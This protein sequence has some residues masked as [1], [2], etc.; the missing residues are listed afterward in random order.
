[1][2]IDTAQKRRSS[3]SFLLPFFTTSVSIDGSMSQADRQ[4]SAW[5]YSGILAAAPIGLQIV[6]LLS[7]SVTQPAITPSVIQPGITVSVPQP[8]LSSITVKNDVS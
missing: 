8:T 6:T 7:A 2:A 5:G 3:A 4:E 1:M